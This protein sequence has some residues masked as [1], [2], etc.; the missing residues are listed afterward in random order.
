M[1]GT[2]FQNR[3]V[4]LPLN[5]SVLQN[6]P[7]TYGIIE[8]Q[9]CCRLPVAML[10]FTHTPPVKEV[11]HTDDKVIVAIAIYI[12]YSRVAEDMRVHIRVL[13]QEG[14]VA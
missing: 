10:A 8:L 11:A 14:N 5:C 9:H 2:L 7:F 12:P 13:C 4:Y 6:T 1:Y 3:I